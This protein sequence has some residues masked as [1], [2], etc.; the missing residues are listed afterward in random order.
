M[1]TDYVSIDWG[2]THLSGVI[3]KKDNTNKEFDLEACNLKLA[4][5][6]HLKNICKNVLKVFI[7]VS[8]FTYYSYLVLSDSPH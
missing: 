3:I 5:D 1:N 4:S 8:A 6:E 2:G 7:T